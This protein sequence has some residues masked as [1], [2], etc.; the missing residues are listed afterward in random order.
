MRLIATLNRELFTPELRILERRAAR[1]IIMRDH[2]ILLLYTRRYNDYSLPGGGL[3]DGEAV[4]AGLHRELAEETGAR[5]IRVEREFGI[6]DEYRPWYKPEHD[7][8]FMRSYFYECSVAESL[9]AVRMEDYEIANGMEVRWMN[10]HD[11]I[12]HNHGVMAAR[13]ASMGLSIA[14]ETLILELLVRE[15]LAPSPSLALAD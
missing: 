3:D 9:G 13:E 8:M 6:L 10:I 5:D 1:G 7:L 11:A 2:D 14:R 15:R 4:L 12:A